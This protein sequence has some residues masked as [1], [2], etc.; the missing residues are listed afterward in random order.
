MIIG[1]AFVALRPDSAQFGKEAEQQVAGTL[2]Q[3]VKKGAQIL[4][5]LAVGAKVVNVFKEGLDELKQASV[6]QGQT[7]AA[8]QSTGGAA[9]VTSGHVADL[10]TQIQKLAGFD[11]E[12]VQQGENL[13]LTFTNIRNSAGAGND[14]FDRTTQA[15]ADVA[16]RMGT[17]VPAAAIQLGKAL[18]DPVRGLATLTRLGITFSDQQRDQIKKLTENNDLLGAQRIVLDELNKE[19]GGSA[20]ALGDSLA[21]SLSKAEQAS[22]NAK[23]E[24][25]QGLA[26]AIRFTATAQTALADGLDA[27]PAPLQ[28]AVGLVGLLGGAYVGLA[29]PIKATVGLF[30]LLRGG[31]ETQAAIQGTL[32][33]TASA[34][35]VAET[36]L[37]IAEQTLAINSAAAVDG[38]YATEAAS[39][40]ILATMGP[41]GIAAGVAG[42]ALLL[43]GRD[44]K[45]ASV[46]LGDL[47]TQMKSLTDDLADLSGSVEVSVAKSLTDSIKASED[48]AGLFSDLGITADQFTNAV[49]GGDASFSRFASNT[50][51]NNDKVAESLN[52]FGFSAEDFGKAVSGSDEE[53]SQFRT[54]VAKGIPVGT[55]DVIGLADD[56]RNLRNALEDAGKKAINQAVALGEVSDKQRD[57]AITANTAK[58]GTVDY[59]GAVEDLTGESI[60]LDK[61][62]KDIKKSA[63]EV[64]KAH[65][66]QQQA[67]EDLETTYQNLVDSTIGSFNASLRLT[68]AQLASRDAIRELAQAQKDGNDGTRTAA[69]QQDLLLGLQNQA[70]Q[71]LLDQADAL[72]AVT[73]AQEEA[74]GG[75]F[76]AAEK[77]K[78]YKDALGQVASTLAPDSPLRKQL[79]LYAL[80]VSN[81]PSKVSTA[82]HA[83]TK[84]AG[85]AIDIFVGKMKG[86]PKQVV[87]AFK[88]GID[89]SGLSSSSFVGTGGATFASGGLIDPRPG[90]LQST[91][92]EAGEPEGVFPLP[93]GLV[94]GLVA[95]GKGTGGVGG[96]M[97]RD[98][99]VH[100]NDPDPQHIAELA[101]FKFQEG[102][103]GN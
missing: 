83:N 89:L 68:D 7:T 25:V 102:G 64:A 35:A 59:L 88:A 55:A 32:A 58:N 44:S 61:A 38:L 71:A 47:Q 2:S 28:T 49:L 40:G 31:Q 82:F 94:E 100:Q 56:Y 34:A 43:F 52:R 103:L 62:Q 93:P 67:A 63:D 10:A 80:Q 46:D 14:I 60:H 15:L 90:G 8:I 92:A 91:I 21:G 87:L 48:L 53:F 76:T 69:E 23:A 24:L 84:E 41:I 4:G 86:I 99:V 36:D 18:N 19:F 27:L 78:A 11:D 33:A 17:D 42:A 96:P 66:R 22:A 72:V 97:F 3:V 6:V 81:V 73:Q 101:Y 95:I 5:G 57:A 37:A 75:T 29:E 16:A 77:Q 79:E 30:Q 98:L 74:N 13:L 39:T 50:V 65:Q 9:Q 51:I 26:P 85:D 45:G 12:A 20:K 54:D 70:N 1:E